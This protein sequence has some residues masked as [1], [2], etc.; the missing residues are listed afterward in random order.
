MSALPILV[1]NLR[2]YDMYTHAPTCDTIIN[3]L[4]THIKTCDKFS[5]LPPDHLYMHCTYSYV[6]TS[7]L[8]FAGRIENIIDT[9]YDVIHYFRGNEIMAGNYIVQNNDKSIGYLTQWM[10]LQLQYPN[11][12]PNEDNGALHL[13]LIYYALINDNTKWDKYYQTGIDI[14]LR[15]ARGAFVSCL[16]LFIASLAILFFDGVSIG[17]A[18]INTIILCSG[19]GA[20]LFVKWHYKL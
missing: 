18:L 2:N 6:D 1:T 8:N 10:K 19:V 4:K 13:N 20:V 5:P 7:V 16:I 15:F 14:Y 3:R 12:I 9:K 11:M 17:L